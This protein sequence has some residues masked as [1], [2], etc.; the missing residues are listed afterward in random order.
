MLKLVRLRLRRLRRRPSQS[1]LTEKPLPQPQSDRKFIL[2][3][4]AVNL[5]GPKFRTTLVQDLAYLVFD[6]GLLDS[7][8]S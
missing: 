5:D 7:S 6:A 1:A 2:P 3:E 4:G 8:S